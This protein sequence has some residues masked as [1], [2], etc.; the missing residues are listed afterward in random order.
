MTVSISSSIIAK[1]RWL[2]VALYAI[3]S[4]SIKSA[5]WKIPGGRFTTLD[6][7]VRRWFGDN[8]PGIS[9]HVESSVVMGQLLTTVLASTMRVLKDSASSCVPWLSNIGPSTLLTVQICFSHER[10]IWLAD[11]TLMLNQSQS[12]FAI[13]HFILSWFISER[14]VLS[15]FT[16]PMKCNPWSDLNCLTGPWHPTKTAVCV[17]EQVCHEGCCRFE[18]Y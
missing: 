4:W 15:S 2:N 8:T 9:L 14:A 11:G 13:S 5:L 10:P 17:E 1:T 12:F 3:I 16:A 6:F 18:M 7:C